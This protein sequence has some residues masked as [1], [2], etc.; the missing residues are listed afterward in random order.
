MATCW[1]WPTSRPLSLTMLPLPSAPGRCPSCQ[2][3]PQG[4]LKAEVRPCATTSTNRVL[5]RAW[6]GSRLMGSLRVPNAKLVPRSRC[7]KGV[8]DPA[9]PA[10]QRLR[11]RSQ[12]RL[13]PSLVT[14]GIAPVHGT[15]HAKSFVERLDDHYCRLQKAWLRRTICLL[16]WQND[17]SCVG[18]VFARHFSSP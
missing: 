6:T 17:R 7:H 3:G 1:H 13:D 2:K 12:F 5:R 9:N 15:A 16:N 18:S 4:A 11:G 14:E 8:K 10:E